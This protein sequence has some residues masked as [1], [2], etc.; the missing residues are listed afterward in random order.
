[1]DWTGPLS[2]TKQKY[3]TFDDKAFGVA[4]ARVWN[5][6]GHLP[7]ALRLL[8]T[9]SKTISRHISSSHHTAAGVLF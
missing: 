6:L 5:N 8:W 1:V 7:S 9:P 4:A 3:R 2:K